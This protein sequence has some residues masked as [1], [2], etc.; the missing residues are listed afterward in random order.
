[1]VQLIIPATNAAPTI[2]VG[3]PLSNSTRPLCRQSERLRGEL[4]PDASFA[5]GLS[6]QLRSHVK[7]EKCSLASRIVTYAIIRYEAKK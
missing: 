4:A 5:G 1:V 2:A 6:L 7:T 3:M